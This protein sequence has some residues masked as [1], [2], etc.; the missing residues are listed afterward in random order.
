[1]SVQEAIKTLYEYCYSNDHCRDCQFEEFR[2][3]SGMI[4]WINKIVDNDELKQKA[5]VLN[6]RQ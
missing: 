2:E 3:D 4:C 5:E 1:M 6:E